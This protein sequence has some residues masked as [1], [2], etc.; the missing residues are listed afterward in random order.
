MIA[1]PPLSDLPFFQQGRIK[2][3]GVKL[4]AAEKNIIWMRI[5]PDCFRKKSFLSLCPVYGLGQLS[6]LG[7][8]SWSW[9]GWVPRGHPSPSQQGLSVREYLSRHSLRSPQF[10]HLV[11]VFLGFGFGLFVCFVLFFAT[12]KTCGI[13]VPWPGIEPGTLDGE[14]AREFPS[15]SF[16][17]LVSGFPEVLSPLLCWIKE[18]GRMES[19][20]GK[21]E[22]MILW[23]WK[24]SW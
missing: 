8:L 19:P 7:A 3:V 2:D 10:P 16:W 18:D 4:L 11:F 23:T 21:E 15:R 14:S 24:L 1:T 12:C 20:P 5:F 6:G 9:Q 22:S 13:F 17:K